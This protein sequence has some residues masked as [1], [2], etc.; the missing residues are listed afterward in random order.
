MTLCARGCGK[1]ARVRGMC[2]TH[3]NGQRKYEYNRKRWAR[4]SAVGTTRRLRALVA[5]GYTNQQLSELLG[6]GPSYVSKLTHNSRRQVNADTAQKVR[7][8]YDRLSMT[9]GPSVAARDRAHRKGWAV[10][11]AWDDETIDNPDAEPNSAPAAP[12][13]W[14]E[15]YRELRHVGLTD[16][17]IVDRLGIKAES[18]LRQMGRY[19]ITPS[20]ELVREATSAK[21]ERRSAS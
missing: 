9:P 12:V 17:Q 5:I 20:P 7:A 18:L 15:K 14:D 16:L 19:G 8:L 13:R 11:L 2:R 10:P 6:I 4:A 3:Y 1:S 21:Y